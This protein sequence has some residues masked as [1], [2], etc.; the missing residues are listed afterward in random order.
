MKYFFLILLFSKNSFSEGKSG[1]YQIDVK[2]SAGEYFIY[3]CESRHYACV[4]LDGNNSC[5]EKRNYAIKNKASDYAC[6]PLEKF[7]DKKT[8]VEKS[9]KIVDLNAL[10]RFCYPK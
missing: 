6:A 9:Y 4:D 8:C 7:S 1:N 5:K 10:R 3:D 2:Y